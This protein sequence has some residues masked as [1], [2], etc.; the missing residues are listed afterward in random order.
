MLETN[1]TP[2][3]ATVFLAEDEVALLNNALDELCHG[4]RMDDAEFRIRTGFTREEARALLDRLQ[5]VLA[6]LGDDAAG[7]TARSSGKRLPQ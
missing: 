6:V 3:R 2:R 5:L 4:S 7:T 1:G